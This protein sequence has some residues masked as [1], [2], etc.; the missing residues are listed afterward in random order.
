MKIIDD[1]LIA[2]RDFGW[3]KYPANSKE[4]Y[5]LLKQLIQDHF[6]IPYYT[7]E[8]K[9]LT[10]YVCSL[11]WNFLFEDG[12]FPLNLDNKIENNILKNEY[13][14]DNE[15]AD[16]EDFQEDF[17]SYQQKHNQNI[18]KAKQLLNKSQQEFGDAFKD[19]DINS[20][21]PEN[22]YMS[23]LLKYYTQQE[24]KNIVIDYIKLYDAQNIL[25]NI[26]L[27]YPIQKQISINHDEQDIADIIE[28][29]FNK[30]TNL[31]SILIKN[32]ICPI[33]SVF[34]D[35]NI[36]VPIKSFINLGYYIIGMFQQ[37]DDN[38]LNFVK[39]EFKLST[40]EDFENNK[41]EIVPYIACF[42]NYDDIIK[43][44][45]SILNYD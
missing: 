44:L 31:D 23:K 43:G 36:I 25:R 12:E 24:L 7:R 2:V 38:L 20:T 3:E 18:N 13:D 11:Y 32:F 9:K 35:T 8:N 40:Y 4:R 39:K 45:S 41:E 22:I 29:T 1:F 6:N 42:S 14:N 33:Q 26:I 28:N 5:K 30:F 10:D 17:R 15:F 21:N 34:I 27:E 16:E 37:Q 19:F